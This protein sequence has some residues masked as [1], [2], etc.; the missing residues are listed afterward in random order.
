MNCVEKKSSLKMYFYSDPGVRWSNNWVW[1][2]EF[3]AL[4]KDADP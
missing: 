4:A 2:K 3:E 1:Q